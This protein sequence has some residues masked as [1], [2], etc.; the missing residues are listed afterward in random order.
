L[1][2][3]KHRWKKSHDDS[4]SAT[5]Q[6]EL[7]DSFV[8][9]R[10]QYPKYG[11]LIDEGAPPLTTLRYLGLVLW[12]DGRL[13]DAVC[14]L[15]KAVSLAPNEPVIW[16]TRSLLRA[17]GRKSEAMHYLTASLKLDRSKP[18]SGSLLLVSATRS[19]QDLSR[20]GFSCGS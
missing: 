18:W 4:H 5:G 15:T 12:G 19:R 8:L 7:D 11:A 16:R 6:P 14:V 3:S 17:G 1:D 9:W 2:R 20:T 13:D 10:S